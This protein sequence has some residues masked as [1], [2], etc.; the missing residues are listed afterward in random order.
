MQVSANF[1][2]KFSLSMETLYPESGPNELT[3]N[4]EEARV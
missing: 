3:P 2:E 1:T 4:Y